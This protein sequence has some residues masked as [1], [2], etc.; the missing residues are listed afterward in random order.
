MARSWTFLFLLFA[1][2]TALADNNLLRLHGSNTIGDKLAPVL[3]EQWLK[4]KG[5]TQ[6]S[7]RETAPDERLVVGRNTDGNEFFVEIHAHGSTTAFADLASGSTDIGMASR[8]IKPEEVSG[9]ARLGKM[10]EVSSEYVIGLDG[11]AVIVNFDN[12]LTTLD[13]ETVR[14][15]FSGELRDWSQLGG[16][17]GAIHVLARDDKSG[18]YDTFK[19]LVLDGGAPLTKGA[20]RYEAS[21]DLVAQVKADPQA[22]GFVGLAYTDGVKPLAISDGGAAIMPESFSVATEDYALS[23]RLYLYVP[24][25]GERWKVAQEFAR[26]AVSTVGQLALEPNGFISQEIE[27]R[28]LPPPADAPQEYAQFVRNAHR[29]SLNF[30]F[31]K[32]VFDLD[33]KAKRDMQRLAAYFAKPENLHRKLLLFG[34]ADSHESIPMRSLVLSVDRAD[35]VADMLIRNGLRPYRV[36]GYGSA[37]EVASNNSDSGRHRNR[38]VEVWV[39]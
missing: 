38:R 4:S 7:V 12:P 11:V 10:N 22:I 13:K 6:V 27:A 16:K 37:V 23:R 29:L 34:F 5:Y 35:T 28:H 3:A 32:G 39:Q 21:V 19:N 30:R 8:P 2:T 31:E 20:Q 15:I 25:R 36:R 18:T 24:T 26:F 17:P 9:L 33:N 1:A 14:R